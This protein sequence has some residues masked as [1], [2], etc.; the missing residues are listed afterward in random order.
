VFRQVTPVDAW[1]TPIPAAQL[2]DIRELDHIE[3]ADVV[4]GEQDQLARL[5]APGTKKPAKI[6]FLTSATALCSIS[7]REPLP[8]YGR[9][10]YIT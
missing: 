8:G 6:S 10:C 4:D 7:A 5:L 3:P 1:A 9:E 2:T